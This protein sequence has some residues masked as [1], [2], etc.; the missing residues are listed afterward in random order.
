MSDANG[1]WWAYNN[2]GYPVNEWKWIDGNADGVAEC[3]Y[4]GPDGYMLA[5]TMTPDGYTVDGNGAWTVNGA[6]QVKQTGVLQ[7]A[8]PQDGTDADGGRW[9]EESG[10]KKIYES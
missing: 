2:G 4:F 7:N 10:G 6:V 8:T 3:Y 5:N 9:V 1:W